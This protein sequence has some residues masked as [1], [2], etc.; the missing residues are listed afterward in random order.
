M[1]ASQF[2]FIFLS[3]CFCGLSA[4]V[5]AR[6]AQISGRV[7]DRS[8]AAV[9]QAQ[10][11]VSETKWALTGGD[12]S[13]V[14]E[15]VEPGAYQLNV[16]KLGYEA[17]SEEITIKNGETAQITAVL[18]EKV[19]AERPVV[20][21]ASRTKKDLEAVSVPVTVV[22]KQ[23]IE[24]SGSMRLSDILEEQIGLN[25]ISNHGTGVQVQGFDPEYTLIMIDNQPVIGTV[26]G[27]LDLERL[28]IGDVE[29]IEIVKGPSSALWGS[30]A[31][32]GVINIITEKSKE[33]VSLN[34]S[35]RFGTHNNY[36]G[37]ANFSVKTKDFSGRIFGNLNGSDGYDLN[38]A[39]IA[40]TVPAY[41]NHTFSG[42]LGYRLSKHIALAAKGR[43]YSENQSY[44]D[45][46]DISEGAKEL[47][48]RDVRQN[49][50]FTP[51]VQIFAGSRQLLD[52]TAHFSRFTYDSRLKL[53]AT[54]ELNFRESFDQALNKYE[55]KSSTFWNKTQTTVA[56]AGLNNE[57][58][59][60]EIYAEVPDHYSFFVFAQ[61]EYDLSDQLALTGG[62]R[63]DSHNEYSS[64]LSPKFSVLFR[65]SE[66]IHFKASAG[67][68]FKAPDFS[69]LYLDFT[70][71]IAGY[72]V[73][74]STTVKEGVAKVE[75]SG[76]LDELY[77]NP[78]DIDEIKAEHSFSWN[79]GIDV[80]PSDEL[81]VKVNGFRN[82][83]RDL[84]ETQRIGL[85]TNGQSVFTYINLNR[86]YTQGF[87]A[88]ARYSPG[89]LSGLSLAAGYQFLD[90]RQLITREFDEVKD[91]VVI[92]HRKKEYVPMF[93]RSRHSANL[94]IYYTLESL[95]IDLS[96]R[97]QHRGRYGF[98][99]LNAN[100]I[101]DSN[102]YAEAH[103]IINTSAA[104]YFGSRVKL[105]VGVDNITNYSNY[106]FLPSNPGITF[107]TQLNIKLY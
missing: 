88:E 73:F 34:A 69:Q 45:V 3:V 74:G 38:K 83:V 49:Y 77:V 59:K 51:E 18:R 68:G 13:F 50:N 22:N 94:K 17:Y 107:Y 99:D 6:Q 105:Q 66:K 5:C 1:L 63:Y 67:S 42:D 89:F 106:R 70:N 28:T 54:G 36:D 43:F 48:G 80:Y 55:L 21:T 65:P 46:S 29:Q 15:D 26:A 103:T 40:P 11:Y 19:Y 52:L 71:P 16:T 2:K 62:F 20:V 72:S 37:A 23:E 96:M 81:I 100:D 82:N 86:I 84:I 4:T 79:A 24:R 41:D 8:R 92:S 58:L 31:L 60:G 90:A 87:E 32:A 10:V 27:T 30:D 56:G 47:D 78:N 64:Q 95:G 14:I 104:K 98:A 76:Q 91:G 53:A 12:G 9:P 57:G 25:I 101:I 7:E 75:N 97:L 102:E 85:K 39:T 93:N 33:P 44:K 61:H 35:G